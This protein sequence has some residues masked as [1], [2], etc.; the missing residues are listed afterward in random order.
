MTEET[1]RMV[2]RTAMVTHHTEHPIPP[3]P[4]LPPLHH[5]SLPGLAS[6]R[7]PE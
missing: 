2:V 6:C 3:S 5:A 1:L 4:T 7:V